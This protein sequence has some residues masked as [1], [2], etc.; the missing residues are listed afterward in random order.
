MSPMCTA[1]LSAPGNPRAVTVILPLKDLQV[2][3]EHGGCVW[4]FE[5]CLINS[6]PSINVQYFLCPPPESGFCPGLESLT[7]GL[8][9]HFLK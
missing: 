5:W 1:T 6:K 8:I 7:P 9:E 2:L 3:R 4:C